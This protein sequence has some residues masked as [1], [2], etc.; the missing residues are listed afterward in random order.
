MK[1]LR[2]LC[3]LVL[4][5][6]PVVLT[7]MAF[8]ADNSNSGKTEYFLDNIERLNN[9][10][11]FHPE[12]AS[13][14]PAEKIPSGGYVL[15]GSHLLLHYRSLYFKYLTMVMYSPDGQITPL[16]VN[17]Y[18]YSSPVKTP[19][20]K[21]KIQVA[22]IEGRSAVMLIASNQ[23]LEREKIE[24]VAKNPDADKFP[25]NVESVSFCHFFIKDY[26]R[27]MSEGQ[28]QNFQPPA[29][30]YN[31]PD[32]H[33]GGSGGRMHS[34]GGGGYNQGYNEPMYYPN[35]GFASPNQ[36]QYGP[37]PIPLS[38]MGSTYYFYPN[39]QVSQNYNPYY[40]YPYYYNRP[41]YYG[42]PGDMHYNYNP[43]GQRYYIIPD[44]NGA[45]TNLQDF[46]FEANTN[47]GS[48]LFGENG[49]LG[50]KFYFDGKNPATNGMVFRFPVK[51]TWEHEGP[52]GSW[53]K[54]VPSDFDF[55]LNGRLLPIYGGQMGDPFVSIP[56]QGFLINGLNEF[57]LLPR[58]NENYYG[59]GPIEI[60]WDLNF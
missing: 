3:I 53:T 60:T 15:P 57:K 43:Q 56:M 50:G 37:E 45:R 36:G 19:I 7:N 28:G 59:I 11:D 46:I 1:I 44:A 22:P 38:K 34:R 5:F 30:Q 47:Y 25:E 55:Y 32:G 42:Y 52:D 21:E 49:F 24:E 41:M 2:Q 31:A 6:L 13:V 51:S 54:E 39:G 8:A 12:V 10:K 9:T 35:G 48:F 16:F 4:I 18:N 58:S 33:R 23:K 40:Y 20:L 29:G 26:Y 17:E 14:W 27:A